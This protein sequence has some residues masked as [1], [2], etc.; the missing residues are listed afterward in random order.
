MMRILVA[1]AANLRGKNQNSPCSVQAVAC[2][3]T[4]DRATKAEEKFLTC[5]GA[6]NTTATTTSASA[7]D[8]AAVIVCLVL[9]SWDVRSDSTGLTK[10]TSL[11][12]FLN[13]EK[14]RL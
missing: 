10:A 6:T 7:H 9:R 11:S 12:I 1:T 5:L 3:H 8:A 4:I 13:R 2:A 14:A